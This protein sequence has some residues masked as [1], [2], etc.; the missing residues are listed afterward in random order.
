MNQRTIRVVSLLTRWA[1]RLTGALVA[2]LIL[3]VVVGE[4][5]S[6]GLPP[7]RVLFNPIQLG[8]WASIAGMILG[9]K[10]ET[11][12]AALILLACV[13]MNVYEHAVTGRWLGGAF[14][15]FWFPGVLLL[16]SAGLHVWE[17]RLR[18]ASQ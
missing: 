11:L 7:L 18:L 16:L 8:I 12:G 1:A 17:K 15:L 5:I 3:L 13:G 10:W 14:P 9:W 2:G 4:S 6:N